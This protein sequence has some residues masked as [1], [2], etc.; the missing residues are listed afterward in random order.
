M[1]EDVNGLTDLH[2]IGNRGHEHE[3]SH[4]T[5]DDPISTLEGFHSDTYRE[6]VVCPFRD[7]CDVALAEWRREAHIY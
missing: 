4:E 3:H 7:S 6:V 1:H 5:C 2:D